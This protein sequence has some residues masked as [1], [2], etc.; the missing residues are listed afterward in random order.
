VINTF[1]VRVL[2]SWYG[3]CQ[4]RAK[5]WDFEPFEYQCSKCACFCN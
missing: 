1:S 3:D 5:I 2:W 4:N